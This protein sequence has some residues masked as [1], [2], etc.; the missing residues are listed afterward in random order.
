MVQSSKRREPTVQDAY[1]YI[2]KAIYAVANLGTDQRLSEEYRAKL[3]GIYSKLVVASEMTR[4]LTEQ[5]PTGGI[6]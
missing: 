3:N 4:S 5:S 1:Y 2:G 6:K